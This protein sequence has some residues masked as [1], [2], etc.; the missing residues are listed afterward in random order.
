MR[1][2][3][4]SPR[5]WLV[6]VWSAEPPTSGLSAWELACR[7]FPTTVLAGQGLFTLPVDDRHRP[8]KT[9]TAGTQR[10]RCAHEAIWM[11]TTGAHEDRPTL[12]GVDLDLDLDLDL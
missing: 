9:V 4:R 2:L 1:T 7:A 11:Q 12:A 8:P 10:A 3:D 6:H 5:G